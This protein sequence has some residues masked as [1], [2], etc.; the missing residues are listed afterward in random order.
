MPKWPLS[1]DDLR[2]MYAGGS[3]N[4][5]AKWFAR[6][7]AEVFATGVFPRRWVTLEVP[8]RRTGRLQRI[9]VG[10]TDVDGRWYLVSMLGECNWTKNARA[11]GDRVALRHGVR[12]ECGLIEVPVVSR[13]PILR[14]YVDV[15]PGGRPHIPVVRGSSV[16]EFQTIAERYPVFEVRRCRADGSAPPLR[17]PRS[18]F[19]VALAGVVA[20]VVVV[21]RAVQCRAA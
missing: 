11:N 2:A 4:R 15:A 6:L 10:L 9:P 19:P 20:L 3:A 18:W 5:D 8:G 14:R 7:W 12:I 13:G 16:E 1:D 21:R 17:P